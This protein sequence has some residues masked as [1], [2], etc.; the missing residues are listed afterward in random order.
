[1]RLKLRDAK[2]GDVEQLH[3]VLVDRAVVG[4]GRDDELEKRDETNGTLASDDLRV[5]IEFENENLVVTAKL[6]HAEACAGSIQ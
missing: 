1:M 5:P 6:G 3:F 4:D 2:V